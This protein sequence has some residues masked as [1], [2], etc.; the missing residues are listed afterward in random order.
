MPSIFEEGSTSIDGRAMDEIADFVLRQG[1]PVPKHQ[2]VRFT[3][4]RVP[5]HTVL[6]LLDVMIHAGR[7]TFDQESGTFTVLA[8]PPP[9][10]T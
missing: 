9:P 2:V 4:S 3:S 1:R 6:K 10:K 8:L 5:A 7:F